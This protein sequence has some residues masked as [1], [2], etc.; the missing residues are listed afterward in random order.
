MR[1][2]SILFLIC[3]HTTVHTFAQDTAF[4]AD[5]WKPGNLGDSRYLWLPL[6]WENGYP[7][8]RWMDNWSLES[9]GQLLPDKGEP[10]DYEGYKLVWHDEFDDEGAPDPAVWSFEEGFVRNNEMQWYQRENA[11]LHDGR[12]IISGRREKRENPLYQ[13]DSNNWRRSREYI[14]Y[15][16][17][18]IKTE[19]RKEVQYGRFEIRAKIPTANGAWPAIWTL[20]REMEWPSNGEID[21]MEYYRIDGKPHILANTAWGTNQRF[22]AKWDSSVTPFTHFTDK[23]PHWADK[24]HIWRMDWD[25]EAI[26]LYLDGE[27]LNDTLLSETINGSTGDFKNPFKQPH[28]LLLNLAIGGQHGGTPDDRAFPLHYEIDYVRVYQKT[29]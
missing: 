16:S 21:L 6:Q 1:M 23:D 2:V 4:M 18:S 28:Y 17:S 10:N 11:V 25:E 5:R 12:L 14:E 22:N 20:G 15:S 24:F 13:A 27:L 9:F 3:L 8:I 19:G 29:N 26:R 7:V